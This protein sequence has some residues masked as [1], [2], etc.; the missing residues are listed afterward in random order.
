MVNA[1][2]A[3]HNTRVQYRAGCRCDDCR[4]WKSAENRKHAKKRERRTVPATCTVCGAE[5]MARSQESR[6]CS[7]KCVNARKKVEGSRRERSAQFRARYGKRGSARHLAMLALEKAAAGTTGG[8]RVFVSGPCIMCGEAYTS[9]GALA[10]YCSELCRS[11]NRNRAHGLTLLER[12]AIFARD[13]WE[14]H[15]CGGATDPCADPLDDAYPTLDH[16]TPRSQGGTHEPSNLATAHR[17]CNSVRRDQSV[18]D[19]WRPDVIEELSQRLA[20]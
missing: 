12:T 7:A 1:T 17:I 5:Y 14:C 3:P 13:N 19:M 8:A 16:L 4:A 10:R 20:S 18:W 2:S 9:P 15:I 6:H 11:R